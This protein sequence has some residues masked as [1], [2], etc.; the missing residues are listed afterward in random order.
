MRPLKEFIV[1]PQ[2]PHHALLIPEPSLLICSKP[3]MPA[4]LVSGNAT[5]AKDAA[6][7][8][9]SKHS[10]HPVSPKAEVHSEALHTC[11]PPSSFPA[12]I[13]LGQVTT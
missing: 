11:H 13:S 10:K 8:P 1:V 9:E 6:R 12:Y 5:E 3:D 4:L 2:T 7:A